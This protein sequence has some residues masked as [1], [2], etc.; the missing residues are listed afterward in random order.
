MVVYYFLAAIACWIGI[1]SL[2]GGFR[3]AAYVRRETAQPLPDFQPFV[4]VIAP[5]RGLEPGLAENLRPLL[6][7]DY[8]RYE[9]LFVFDREDDPAVQVVEQLISHGF[10]RIVI[11]GSATDSGQKVHNLRVA[12]D[13]ID[14]QSE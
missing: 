2:S 14:A 13:E 10:S 5:G 7:Q 6:T 11:A 1:K 9:V 12:V 8:P 4:S 3:F